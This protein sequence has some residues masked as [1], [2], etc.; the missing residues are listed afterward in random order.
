M[1]LT[2]PIPADI[3]FTVA[4]FLQDDELRE[5]SSVNL[6]FFAAAMDARYQSVVLRVSRLT[7]GADCSLE[8]LLTRLRNPTIAGRVR[9]LCLDFE[10]EPPNATNTSIIDALSSSVACFKDVTTL[11][12]ACNW[13][14]SNTVVPKTSPGPQ[15]QLTLSSFVLP[16]LHALSKA[17]HMSLRVLHLSAN[18]DTLYMMVQRLVA[19]RSLEELNIHFD[20]RSHGPTTTRFQDISSLLGKRFSHLK[21]LGL[22]AAPRLDIS[23]L[24]NSLGRLPSL[25]VVT[26]SLS[27]RMRQMELKR[28]VRFIGDNPSIHTLNMEG[29]GNTLLLTEDLYWFTDSLS[30]QTS[31]GGASGISSL[32]LPVTT[33]TPDMVHVLS[34]KFPLLKNLIFVVGAVSGDLLVDDF[35][36]ELGLYSFARWV[37][38]ATVMS[39]DGIIDLKASLAI[40]E[41]SSPICRIEGRTQDAIRRYLDAG[42]CSHMAVS[43]LGRIKDM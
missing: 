26:F 4:R 1:T 43:D 22:S 5:L 41:A 27:T 2:T 3:W 36:G 20:T 38:G 13:G 33:L 14:G 34:A 31:H 37:Q 35:C 40:A 12:V 18:L 15:T 30:Q 23:F 19:S 11:R 10:T 28:F 7:P 32:K 9:H 8:G 29:K 39:P 42:G 25:E 17:S 24:F 21:R 6:A 16:V